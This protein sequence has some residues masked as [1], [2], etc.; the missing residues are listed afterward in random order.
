MEACS[1][2]F[3]PT[4]GPAN[5]SLVRFVGLK[6]GQRGDVIGS[7]GWSSSFTYNGSPSTF[8]FLYNGWVAQRVWESLGDQLRRS[9]ALL[10]VG[11]CTTP[12][13]RAPGPRMSGLFALAP[14]EFI[15]SKRSAHWSHTM[16][17]ELCRNRP[18]VGPP[19][20]LA[21]NI[22]HLL[23]KIIAKVKLEALRNED[24]VGSIAILDRRSTH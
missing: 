18:L 5:G 2:T 15:L 19:S 17:V 1:I 22:F 20:G 21:L 11:A 3:D 23:D 24:D 4:D 12:G 7:P 6:L 13:E 16:S 8:T 14:V 10:G 9:S